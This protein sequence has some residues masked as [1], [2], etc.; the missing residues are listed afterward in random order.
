M[1]APAGDDCNAVKSVS[2]EAREGVFLRGK[3]TPAIEGVELRVVGKEQPNDAQPY[4][5]ATTTSDGSYSIGPLHDDI[6]YRYASSSSIFS[7]PIASHLFS[8]DP[9]AWSR[10][11]K[12]CS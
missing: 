7:S 1:E 8:F 12:D 10:T 5:T 3:V 6:Q 4:R 9:V 2:F 11:S